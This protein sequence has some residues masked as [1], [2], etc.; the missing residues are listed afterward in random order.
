M[1]HARIASRIRQNVESVCANLS[2]FKVELLLRA[3]MDTDV[4]DL[5][6]EHLNIEMVSATQ[7]VEF[8]SRNE[9][10]LAWLVEEVLMAQGYPPLSHREKLLQ[11]V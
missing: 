4:S 11:S 10:D 3:N 2:G 5:D 6:I 9:L 8:I 7:I 1:D